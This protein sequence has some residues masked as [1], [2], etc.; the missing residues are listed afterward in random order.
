MPILP[1]L[2]LDYLY[3]PVSYVFGLNAKVKEEIYIR[4]TENLFIVDL[5]N[6]LI[7]SNPQAMKLSNEFVAPTALPPLPTHYSKKMIR[8]LTKILNEPNK[9]EKSLFSIKTC[10]KI[11]D[12]FFQFF[13]S[14][15]KQYKKFMNFSLSHENTGC[16]DEA[17]FLKESPDNAKPF[18]K[19]FF[20]TQMF[21]N[22]CET[23]LRPVNVEE[24]SE[25][26]LFDEC[27][28]AKANR[29]KLRYS[30]FP[31]PFINDETQAYNSCWNVPELSVFQEFEGFV[32]SFFP[33]IDPEVLS[34]FP[35]PKTQPPTYSESVDFP[36]SNPSGNFN[37]RSLSDKEYIYSC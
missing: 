21:A 28:L 26:L 1:E 6:N 32:Y 29:S 15:F 2:L 16:F 22:F 14:I 12:C 27:I 18:F 33:E 31:T 9:Q 7:Q 34:N 4:G 13:V 37:T 10:E 8:K 17:G 30:K 5:D 19:S 23:R 20:K 35:L 24:H 36:Y 25:T 3:S 11:R